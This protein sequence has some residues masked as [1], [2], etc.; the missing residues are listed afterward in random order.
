MLAYDA[1][2][3][4]LRDTKDVQFVDHILQL[5]AEGKPW[6]V[7]DAIVN[8]WASRHPKQY[9][10]FIVEIEEK[11][12]TRENRHASNKSKTLRAIADIPLGV[13]NLIRKVYP[14]EE[15]PFDK[16]FVTRMYKDY[17]SMRVAEKI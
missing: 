2:S 9:K 13:I 6:E 3:E 17:P 7:V 16:K 14:P 10:S 4:K 8:Y 12:A 11:R 15:L 1:I 5:R